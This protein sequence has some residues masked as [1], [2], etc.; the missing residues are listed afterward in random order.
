MAL[1][2]VALTM[3]GLYR[4]A[5]QANRLSDAGSVLAPAAREFCVGWCAKTQK[6]RS[7]ALAAKKGALAD[8]AAFKYCLTKWLVLLTLCSSEIQI[9]ANTDEKV[10]HQR[11][12]LAPRSACWALSRRRP[13]SPGEEI[14]EGS[15]SHFWWPFQCGDWRIELHPFG[16]TAKQRTG[17]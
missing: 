4:A 7:P 16:E 14:V 3:P 17:G 5:V 11:D 2:L 9:W 13:S 8:Q 6:P 1:R 12:D 15:L 10:H